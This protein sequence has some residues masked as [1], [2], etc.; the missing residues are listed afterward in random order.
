MNLYQI[1]EEI[2]N[3]IDAE[4]GEI[5]DVE[6]L[7]SLS[8]RKKQKNW[9]PCLL[10]QESYG[11]CR[12]SKSRKKCLCR[13]GKDRKKTKQN[14]LKDIC[15]QFWME[16]NSLQINAHYLLENLNQL[17]YWTWKHLCL[18]IRRELLKIFW[19]YN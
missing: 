8:I 1:N 9:K 2:E 16:K 14:Q 11:R 5:L 4:T 15:Q 19:T 3:C 12:S 17:K 6:A 18:M 10:V 13:K 7:N